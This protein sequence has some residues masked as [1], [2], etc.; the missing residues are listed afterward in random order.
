MTIF[1]IRHAEAAHSFSQ[2]PNPGLSERGQQQAMRCYEMMASRIDLD[3]YQVISSPLLRAIQTAQP[4]A[5]RAQKAIH[6]HDDFTEIPSPNIPLEDR[7]AWLKTL[8]NKKIHDLGPPQR[9]WFKTILK[10]LSAIKQPCIIITHFMVINAIVSHLSQKPDL[11]SFNP[12]N[13]SITTCQH[14][15]DGSL[16]IT[17]LGDEMPT[18]IG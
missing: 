7:S 11:I 13:T 18:P 15:H 9:V 17:D 1:L 2:S 4:F 5:N 10:A 6:I 3:Q 12:A 16:M 8:F 14:R